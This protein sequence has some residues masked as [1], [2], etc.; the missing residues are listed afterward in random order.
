[1]L[2]LFAIAFGFAY[3]GYGPI[4]ASLTV[5]SFGLGKIGIILGVLNIGY[6]IGAALGPAIGGLIFDASGSYFMAFLSAALTM[7]IVSL[8][9]PLIRRET[10]M[11]FES[12]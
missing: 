12:G 9:I 5:D 2:Y 1:M 4:M 7:G 10:V 11:N 8:L 6:G 3:G